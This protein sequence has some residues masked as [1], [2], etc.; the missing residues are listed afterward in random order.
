M[1]LSARHML[2]LEQL[3]VELAGVEREG[4]FGE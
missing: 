3:E 4:L 1:A 2:F